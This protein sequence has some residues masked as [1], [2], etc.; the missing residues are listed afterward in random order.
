MV[1]TDVF[2]NGGVLDLHELCGS[3]IYSMNFATGKICQSKIFLQGAYPCLPL[4]TNFM[5]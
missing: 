2:N 1:S 3:C 4:T 5:T